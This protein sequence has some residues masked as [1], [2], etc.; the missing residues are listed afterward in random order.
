MT[1]CIVC[2]SPTTNPKFCSRSCAAKHNNTATPKRKPEGKCLKC[3]SPITTKSRYC[4]NC[5]EQLRV[6][7]GREA[8][9]IRRWKT[10]SGDWSEEL[11]QKVAARKRT[12]FS[13]EGHVGQLHA[14]DLT[15]RLL[16]ALIG[17]CFSA[18]EYLRPEDAA[19][20]IAL[21]QELKQFNCEMW[22]GIKRV[23]MNIKDVPI[24]DLGRVINDWILSYCDD[25]RCALLPAFA[26][27]TAV[28]IESHVS[29]HYQHHPVPWEIKPIVEPVERGF[30]LDA[31]FKSNFTSRLG[32]IMV[33]CRVPEA[34]AIEFQGKALVSSGEEFCALIKR[35]HLSTNF[36]DAI[37]L[38]TQFP[39]EATI[40]LDFRF[41]GEILLSG[42]CSILD[43]LSDSESHPI[44]PVLLPECGQSLYSCRLMDLN[45][46]GNWIHSAGRRD[47]DEFQLR[48][49]P[50]WGAEVGNTRH[51]SLKTPHSSVIQ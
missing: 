6:E 30:Q 21:L 51:V 18:P 22:S 10:V 24:R 26:L 1:K 49:L 31:R 48:P 23:H 8:E 3:K 2:S 27:D 43:W 25:N 28:F 36:Q 32:H 50:R 7:Q 20:H 34:C 29:G 38:H 40:D 37:I 42:E 46:P 44:Q 13:V 12:V 17:L 47:N 9:N 19:R 41:V 4:K 5:L 11:V 33:R 14:H 45:I 39:E 15:G 16:D 35:C